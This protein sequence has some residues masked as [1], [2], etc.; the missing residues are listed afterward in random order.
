ML[1]N[2]GASY[3]PLVAVDHFPL[4]ANVDKELCLFVV[5]DVV[6]LIV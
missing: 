2:D 4:F 3:M 1:N 6:S 5:V